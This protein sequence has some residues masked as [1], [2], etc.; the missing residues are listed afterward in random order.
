[1]P[2]TLLQFQIPVV[3]HNLSGYDSH[4]L[5]KQLG[6]T[7]HFPGE[8][9]VIPHNSEKYI[10]SV[11]T[12]QQFG[13]P[14]QKH[15]K[16][17]FIDSLNFMSS[18]LDYL[19]SIVP[20]EKKQI[21]KSECVKSEY[22]S[23]D[24]FALLCRKG[25]FPYDYI[26]HQKKL[27]ETALP[28]KEYFHSLLTDCDVSYEDYKHAQLVWEKFGIRTLGEYSDLYLK[29]D[30]LLLADV[31]ENFIN[32]CF[33]THAL[34]P[35]HYFGASGLSF[36][37][38][39]KYTNVSIELLT[40]IDM[41]MFVEQG[42]RGGVSQINKRYIK[43]NNIYMGEHFDASKETSYILYLDGNFKIIVIVSI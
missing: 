16:F 36:D 35:A 39:L 20:S 24:L 42:I 2:H 6:D 23:D 19:A 31:F 26:D 4:L 10:A 30:V 13:K 3:A 25:I 34:D 11:K 17:K 18:S 33:S 43:A 28:A 41:L 15:I 40:D 32:T 7:W 14:Y 21:L 27:D 12:I 8:L 37:A 5:I 22:D 38:M 29:T 9:T 1:M